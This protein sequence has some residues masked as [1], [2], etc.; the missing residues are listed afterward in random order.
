MDKNAYIRVDS[1]ITGLG[2]DGRNT[3]S[4]KSKKNQNDNNGKDGDY[5]TGPDS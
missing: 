5:M 3:T 4:R 2:S 1:R